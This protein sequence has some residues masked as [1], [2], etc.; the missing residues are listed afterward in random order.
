MQKINNMCKNRAR[1]VPYIIKNIN[2][3]INVAKNIKSDSIVPIMQIS[4]VTSLNLN[5]LKTLFNLLPIRNDFSQYLDKH[6][7]LLID[8]TYS[9]IGHPTIVSGLLKSGKVKVNDTLLIGPFSDSSYKQVKVRSIHLNYRDL[10]EANPGSFICLSLKNVTRKEIKK[11]MILLSDDSNLKISVK[12]FIA[13]IHVLHSPTTIKE[14][15]QPFIHVDH[16]R[17]SVKI[18]QIKKID[19]INNYSNNEIIYANDN[20]CILRTGDKATVQL[21]FISRPEYVKPGMRIIFREGKV[22]AVGKVIELL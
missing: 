17:Q 22:R 20:D 4:N 16:V 12:K 15:Y 14:G 13:L 1:K 9:V 7:E 21:E 8:N 3:V 19:S 11:G 10:K 5:L 6:I 18:T 2:D